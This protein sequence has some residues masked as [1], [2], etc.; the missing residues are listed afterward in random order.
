MGYSPV[1]EFWLAF[2]SPP[3]CRWCLCVWNT[4]RNLV[5]FWHPSACTWFSTWFI[6]ASTLMER[7]VLEASSLLELFT[8][9]DLTFCLSQILDYFFLFFWWSQMLVV[10][11]PP[12]VGHFSRPG[13]PVCFF[14]CPPCPTPKQLF[15]VIQDAFWLSDHACSF[16]CGAMKACPTRPLWVGRT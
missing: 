15:L 11:H 2:F 1:S 4:L 8:L 6:P 3:P 7:L 16:P 9:C 12:D 10:F 14:P 5:C 13:Q